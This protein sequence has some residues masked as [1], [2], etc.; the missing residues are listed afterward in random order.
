MIDAVLQQVEHILLY[1]PQAADKDEGLEL[2]AV[3]PAEVNVLQRMRT[4]PT[5]VAMGPF[6]ETIIIC[7]NLSEQ[8]LCAEITELDQNDGYKTMQGCCNY[9]LA[10]YRNKLAQL[11]TTN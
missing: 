1:L 6:G 11:T 2:V 4:G 5:F 8:R 3:T 7:S 9:L 10:W